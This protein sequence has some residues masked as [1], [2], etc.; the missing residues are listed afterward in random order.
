M[1]GFLSFAIGIAEKSVDPLPQKQHAKLL[2][3]RR[4]GQQ[5]IEEFLIDNTALRRA[6]QEKKEFPDFHSGTELHD[7]IRAETGVHPQAQSARLEAG[8]RIHKPTP[9]GG[10]GAI[11]QLN[12]CLA[13]QGFPT[14]E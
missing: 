4:Q 14:G 11:H 6:L 1:G 3:E 9:F 7:P 8:T 10:G 12:A 13:A 5:L 2:I